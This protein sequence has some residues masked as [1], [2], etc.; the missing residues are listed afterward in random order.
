MF[1][2]NYGTN[3]K[4]IKTLAMNS[5]GDWKQKRQKKAG[6][7]TVNPLLNLVD[8]CVELIYEA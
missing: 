8:R 3:W 1:W 7:V 4:S 6:V 2:S 5:S